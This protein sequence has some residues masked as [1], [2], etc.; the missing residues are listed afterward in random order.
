MN[1]STVLDGEHCGLQYLVS[2]ISHLWSSKIFLSL[3]IDE[4]RVVLAIEP[5]PF[6]FDIELTQF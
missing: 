1:E 6:R 4:L 2:E 3:G 5:L